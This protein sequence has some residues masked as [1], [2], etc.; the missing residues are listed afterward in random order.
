MF[1]LHTWDIGALT[2]GDYE[3]RALSICLNGIPAGF[4][5]VIPGQVERTA[6]AILGIPQPS[7]GIFNVGD[8]ISVTFT[9]DIDCNNIFYADQA[10]LNSI[11]LYD[12]TTSQLVAATVQCLGNKIIIVPNIPSIYMEN[13]T[14]EV[15]VTGIQDFVGNTLGV[16]NTGSL[17]HKW[18][19]YV[20]V[21]PVSWVG[22]AVDEVKQEN[23]A[24]SFQRS[25]SNT[26]GNSVNYSITMPSYISASS[27]SGMLPAGGQVLITFTVDNQ[28]ANGLYTDDLVLNSSFGNE[29]LPMEIRVMCPPP[30]WSFNAAQYS[31]NMNYTVSLDIDGTS[32]EDE[33]DQ[34]AAFV[35]GQVRGIA[36]VQYIS[37]LDKYLAFLSVYGNASDNGAAV[38]FR[39][40]DASD[41][42]LYE[43]VV[44]SFPFAGNGQVGTPLVEDTIHTID[45]LAKTI[46]LNAGWNWISF[47][48]HL[49]N[50]TVTNVMS[51]L[52][53][54]Y[55]GIM[56]SQTQFSQYWDANDVWIG[57]LNQVE[58]ES[59]Y[60]VQLQS[61]DTL[62]FFGSPAHTDSTL[63]PIVQ[64]WNWIGYLPQGGMTPDQA[65]QTLTPYN[66]DIIKN[67]YFFAQY[68]AG[69]GWIGNLNYMNP[70]SGYLYQASTADTLH[71]PIDANAI[72]YRTIAQHIYE[73]RKTKLVNEFEQSNISPNQ[74]SG[75]MNVIGH[76]ISNGENVTAAF[77]KVYAYID[78][79]VRGVTESIYV[80]DFNDNVFFLTVFADADEAGKVVRFNYLNSLTNELYEVEETLVYNENDVIGVVQNEQSLTIGAIEAAGLVNVAKATSNSIMVYPN[81]IADGTVIKYY[82]NSTETV[83]LSITDNLGRIITTYNAT[84][85]AGM[86][87]ITLNRVLNGTDM[88]TGVYHLS[89]KIEGERHMVKLVNQ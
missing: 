7:D 74:F 76:A 41:C 3:V 69:I 15:R 5:E 58:V 72:V 26:G 77:D 34:I 89:V 16:D 8:E 30:A 43:Q 50:D 71:Y 12:L 67:Q 53:N 81:P 14:L 28:L 66:G 36:N 68:V 73:E 18:D 27:S 38:D 44:E 82:S 83:Q 49:A 25:I 17:V 39:V 57:G 4:S 9:E 11:G 40:W 13:H 86:N 84:P 24:H 62:D 21:S 51:G 56:K 61:A 63:I 37:A 55:N 85:S 42:K 29:V 47:N 59:M 19:F 64:G 87:S 20:D 46:N 10:N 1:T 33:F 79:E 80:D 6:P 2:D 23:V 48:L 60:Q 45:L 65:L 31:Y 78:G 32:S 54:P 70:P 35:D 22:T 88:A 52:S 75:N